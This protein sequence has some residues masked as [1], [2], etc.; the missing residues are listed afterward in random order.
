MTPFL[1]AFKPFKLFRSF[2]IVLCVQFILSTLLLLG[3]NR[4]LSQNV[5]WGIVS[6]LV[7]SELISLELEVPLSPPKSLV[8]RNE[9]DLTKSFVRQVVAQSIRCEKG[10]SGDFAYRQESTLEEHNFANEFCKSL[11]PDAIKQKRWDYI[12][13]VPDAKIQSSL[14]TV[15]AKGWIVIWI[16]E[17]KNHAKQGVMM[18]VPNY[19]I[20]AY[21]SIIWEIR[22]KLLKTFFPIL[23][24][25]IVFLGWLM[26]ESL[27]SPLSKIKDRLLVYESKDLKESVEFK[28][29]F[30]EFDDFVR[31]F[32]SL[33]ARLSASFMQAGRFSADASH[34]LRTPL[35]ILRGYVERAIFDCEDGSLEQIRLS[36]MS[37]EIER[38][39]TIT[40]KLLLLSKADA[41]S[42]SLKPT[43]V[44]VSDMASQLV[45]DLKTFQDD[46]AITS[47]IQRSVFWHCDPDLIRQLLNNLC[48]N[49]VN[50]NTA[51]GW[52]HIELHVHRS[53]LTIAFTNPSNS[54]SKDVL[55]KAFERFYRGSGEHSRSTDGHGL[56]LSLCKEIIRL[57]H[58]A[59]KINNNERNEVCVSI[60]VNLQLH[61]HQEALA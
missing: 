30:S 28:T 2:R 48:S 11:Y 56:G 23:L 46:L 37:D 50:Y 19:A 9:F 44:N 55:D 17:Y 25:C 20:D 1:D 10:G 33:T 51:H 21:V 36:Q 16:V 47:N 39:I 40:D 60:E 13:L 43:R 4:W 27:L 35:T 18:A 45:L 54:V 49:A 3:F 14:M 15:R 5:V 7:K 42:L 38:L 52:I 61:S 53:I 8:A 59:I 34:E 24:V 22:D 12:T 31:V 41:G 6:N 58:G 57:H 26:T 29:G 32:N